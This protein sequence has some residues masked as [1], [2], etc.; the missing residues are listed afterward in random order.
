MSWLNWT[1]PSPSEKGLWDIV[2]SKGQWPQ[3]P[4]PTPRNLKLSPIFLPFS[5]GTT[6][7]TPAQPTGP[8]LISASRRES[9]WSSRR[10]ASALTGRLTISIKV[11]GIQ[12]LTEAEKEVWIL[13]S[14]KPLLLLRVTAPIVTQQG[15]RAFPK[16]GARVEREPPFPPVEGS[17]GQK[18]S[19]VFT[20]SIALGS[21]IHSYPLI[22][23]PNSPTAF[24]IT[25]AVTHLQHSSFRAMCCQRICPLNIKLFVPEVP[26]A[27]TGAWF[28]VT[29]SD[30][31]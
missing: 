2:I 16:E 14:E 5:S 24:P 3:W 27:G 23:H 30:F 17:K 9:D 4:P 15:K 20:S 31:F 19:C 22:K 11:Q 18:I 13:N 7:F 21:R 28:L 29:C 12:R 1:L 25:G 6:A 26:I 10:K 8:L